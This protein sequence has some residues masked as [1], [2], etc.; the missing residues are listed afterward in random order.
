[1]LLVL[2]GA[3][4]GCS[5]VGQKAGNPRD[6]GSPETAPGHSR[7]TEPATAEKRAE[8]Y[9]HYATALVEDFNRRPEAAANEFYQA[10][11]L[12][13]TNDELVVEAAQCLLE[14]KENEKALKLLNRA[15]RAPDATGLI[16]LWL[17]KTQAQMNNTNAAIK[18]SQTALKKMP[19]SSA[20]YEQ[21]VQLYIQSGQ[22]K[23]AIQLL[24]DA[25]KKAG[26]NAEFALEIAELHLANRRLFTNDAPAFKSRVADLLNVA[27]KNLPNNPVLRLRLAEAYSSIDENEHALEIYTALYEQNPSLPGLRERLTDFYI[28]TGHPQQ[29]SELLEKLV[30]EQP[31]NPEAYYLLGHLASESKDYQKAADNFR[32]CILL[33]PENQSAYF[34]LAA[35][36][37]ALNQPNTALQTLEPIRERSKQNFLLE[38]YTAIAYN[39]LKDYRNALTHMVTAEIIANA[40]ETNR[41]N[42]MLYFQMGATYERNQDY[43]QAEKYFRK[44]LEL[45]PNDAETLNYLGYM[46]VERGEKLEEA[47]SM[48]EKAV[49]AEPKNPAYLDSLAWALYKLHHADEAMPLM[50][51][52]IELNKEPDATLLDHLGDIYSARQQMDKAREAWKKSL[53][54]EPNEVVKKKLESGVP[55]PSP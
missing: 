21:L 45:N 41:L 52:A 1:M 42:L 9:A 44:C 23:P 31:L 2:A 43:A 26:K 33:A 10:A 14:N 51:Q 34:D 30:R 55:P 15:A 7:T 19:T 8:I 39:R 16:Y 36:Q 3:G 48:I 49:K 29:A 54:I 18:A 5:T 12:D 35:M 11:A 17:G 40:T 32:K 13:P 50:L 46:W 24:N 28:R 47:R 53:A 6:S 4:G 38:F 37:I 25:A 27:A 20:P 22:N